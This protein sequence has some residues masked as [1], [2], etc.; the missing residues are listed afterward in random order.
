MNAKLRIVVF[1]LMTLSVSACGSNPQNLIVGRWE[2]DRAKV[3]GAD[4][5]YTQVA[6]AIHMTAEF[7]ADGTARMTMMEHTFQGTYKLNGDEL[8]W[9]MSG[10]TKKA[11]AKVTAT[12]LEVTDDANQTILYRRK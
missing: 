2:A 4:A 11:R 8:E 5:P 10:I 1:A 3:G 9:S 6:K 7:S 12:E